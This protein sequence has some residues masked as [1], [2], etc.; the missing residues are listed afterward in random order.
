MCRREFD[1]PGISNLQPAE[2]GFVCVAANSIRRESQSPAI[3]ES[4]IS[5]T[6]GGG[7]RMCRR[8]FDSPGISCRESQSAAISS[9]ILPVTEPF[10]NNSWA[11]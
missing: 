9:T 1:S 8:E 3:L 2:A 4:K 6:R 7:F 11:A 10:S 5:S